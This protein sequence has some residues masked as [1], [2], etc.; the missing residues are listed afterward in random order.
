MT[1]IIL[2]FAVR[3]VFRLS[4]ALLDVVFLTGAYLVDGVKVFDLAFNSILNNNL[5]IF[6]LLMIISKMTRIWVLERMFVLRRL[7]LPL[8]GRVLPRAHFV[9][10]EDRQLTRNRSFHVLHLRWLCTTSL[11][12]CLEW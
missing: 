1:F 3:K 11:H 4:L 5:P 10:F 6:Q 2:L 12:G 8:V 9:F 7:L